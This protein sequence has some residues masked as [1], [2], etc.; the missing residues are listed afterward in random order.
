ML[1][2][3]KYKTS[4]ELLKISSI[5]IIKHRDLPNFWV[6]IGTTNTSHYGFGKF[7]TRL[8][9]PLTHSVYS[10]KDSFEAIDRI[11]SIPTE[12]FYEGYRYFSFNVTSLLTNVSFNKTINIILHRI[13]K[14]NLV[15]KNMR[16]SNLKKF[17][18]D[19][20]T[21]TAFSFNGKSYKQFDAV[22]MDP[23]LDPVLTNVIIKE[24]E[25]LVVDQLIKNG[26]IKFYIKFVDDT[27]V[28]AKVEDIHNIMKQSNSFHKSIQFTINEF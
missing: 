25:R 6:I 1:V 12:L 21:K 11:H 28:L 24:F 26:L 13:C 9:N 18:K 5:S 2:I 19:L 23:S 7:W 8:L 3:L 16:K 27:L 20:C 14:E 22:L 17:I 10:I 15:R 4:K